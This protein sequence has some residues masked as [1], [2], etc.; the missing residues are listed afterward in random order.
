MFKWYPVEGVKKE[1]GNCAQ[2]SKRNEEAQ[3]QINCRFDP[4]I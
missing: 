1:Q 2:E 3:Y 4:S